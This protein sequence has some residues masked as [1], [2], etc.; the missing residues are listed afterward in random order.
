[1]S[2]VVGVILNLRDK[3]TSPLNKVNEKLG[4]TEKKIKTS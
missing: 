4:T 1:M 2:K 3:F